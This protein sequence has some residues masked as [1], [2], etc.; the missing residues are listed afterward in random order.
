MTGVL[1]GLLPCQGV[2]D[3][4]PPWEPAQQKGRP[5]DRPFSGSGSWS[6]SVG[7]LGR[8]LVGRVV[9]RGF[10]VG[11]LVIGS[12]VAVGGGAR[13]DLDAVQEVVGHLQ[14]L[15]VLGVRRHVG[16]RAGLFLAAIGD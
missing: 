15:V 2:Q 13:V 6:R 5:E 11:S 16:L 10:V 8:G 4:G 7:L 3:L 12:L 14:R 9:V 1:W